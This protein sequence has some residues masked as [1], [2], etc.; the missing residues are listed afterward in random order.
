MG[1]MLASRRPGTRRL[2]RSIGPIV[3]PTSAAC[4][5]VRRLG[6]CSGSLVRFARL[7]GL[8]GRL[9]SLTGPLGP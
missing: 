1:G 7:G 3:L 9:P 2:S 4:R 5:M 6:L 8:L